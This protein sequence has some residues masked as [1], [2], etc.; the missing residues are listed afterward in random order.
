MSRPRKGPV[1]P[2]TL[3]VLT[4]PEVLDYMR[5]INRGVDRKRILQAIVSGRLLAHLDEL[6]H[7]RFGHPLT[8]I[9]RVDL[10]AWLVATMP[11][12]MQV[13]A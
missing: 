13:S 8:I 6:R 9:R 1:D 2:F 5:K 11:P 3:S 4:I 12:L 10:E 7:D